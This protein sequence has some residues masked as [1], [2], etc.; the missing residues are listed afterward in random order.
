MVQVPAADFH[1]H[2]DI[3]W[4]YRRRGR[5]TVFEYRH[6]AGSHCD[7]GIDWHARGIEMSHGRETYR[8]VWQRCWR[9]LPS[10]EC[11]CPSPQSPRGMEREHPIT[12]RSQTPNA[13]AT[14]VGCVL[15]IKDNIDIFDI[16]KYTE[17]WLAAFLFEPAGAAAGFGIATL[18]GMDNASRVR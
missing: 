10:H 1:L 4:S 7:S 16:S 2:H 6:L 14:V 18:L 12:S 17:L 3:S 9:H 15:G 5:H 11:E 8:D 13:F